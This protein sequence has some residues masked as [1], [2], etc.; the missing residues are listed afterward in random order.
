MIEVP[1]TGDIPVKATTGSA[2]FDLTAREGRILYPGQRA[3]IPTGLKVAIPEGW[4]GFVLSRSG[5]AANHGV[6]VLNAPGLIDSDYRGEI[7]VIMHN[8]GE[9]AFAI[10][11][12]DRIA[13]FMLVPN[14]H[15]ELKP[16][17][18]LHWTERGAGGFGSSGR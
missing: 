2:A 13:Q 5:L 16:V 8:A 3:I 7:G 6:A 14:P 10:H 4:A 11:P 12:G 18:Y 9:L 15:V 17:A 1:A